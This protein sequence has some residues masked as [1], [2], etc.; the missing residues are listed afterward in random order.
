MTTKKILRFIPGYNCKNQISRV[1]GKINPELCKHID[2]VIF[3]N[4]RST[5]NT[6]NVAI[7]HFKTSCIP[8]WKVFRNDG[9]Y[10]LGGSHKVAINFAIANDF[11][12]LI[13]LHGDDQGSLNDLE[14]LLARKVY[15]TVDC[16]LVA[17]FHKESQLPGYSAFRTFGNKAFNGLFSVCLGTQIVDLGAGLNMY[18]VSIFKDNW[19]KTLPD[20][21]T[22][23]YSA[24]MGHIYFHRWCHS[25]CLLNWAMPL[26]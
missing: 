21:L 1:I 23:N 16:L 9:N 12:H 4:N 25:F 26:E 5:D 19:Y 11:D 18:K 14:G 20:D 8:N 2:T 6:E 13:V 24:I 15:E 22:F 17:R 10:G 7:E 3:V